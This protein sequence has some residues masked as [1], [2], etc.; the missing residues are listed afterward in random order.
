MANKTTAQEAVN[1]G[2]LPL[3]HANLN[4]PSGNPELASE[5]AGQQA[6]DKS[7]G[8]T[9][10]FDWSTPTMLDTIGGQLQQLYAGQVTPQQLADAGQKDYDAF[11]AQRAKG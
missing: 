5:I 1:H 10:Y 11:Q 6:L 9:P 2:L 8:Y 7:N 3:L 4:T